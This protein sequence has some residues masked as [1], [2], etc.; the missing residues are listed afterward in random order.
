MANLFASTSASVYNLM[1]FYKG[2]IKDEFNEEVPIYR[3]AETMKFNWS[4]AQVNRP[5]R[6][7][8]NQGIGASTDGGNLPAIGRQGGV[9]AVIQAKYHWLRFGLTAGLLK[10]AQSDKGSFVRQF[11]FEMEMGMKDFKSDANRIAAWDGTGVLATVNT[12]AAASTSLVIAGR[13]SS[14]PALKFIGPNAVVDIYTSAGVLVQSSVTITAIASGGPNDSTATLTV[15][16]AVTCSATNIIVRSGSYNNEAQGLLYALDGGTSTIYSVDRSA[17]IQYQGNVSTVSGQLT[18]DS[19]Q[20]A[21]NAAEQ[22]GGASIKNVYTD[23]LSRRYYQKLLTA[24]K[25]YVNTVKGDGSFSSESK[26][27]LEWNGC[28]WVA[29]KDCPTR[30]FL[31][32]SD[33]IEKAVLCEMEP[34]EETGSAYIAQA[35]VDAWEVRVRHFYN[36]FNALPAGCAAMKSYTSP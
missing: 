10:A 24:D 30:I 1:N 34:A 6:L 19:I 36:Y 27:Y 33:A 9:Q 20:G 26:S 8:R 3:G 17:Y 29:D 5:L 21:Q 35:G 31:L 22:R 2:P 11:Q 28:P 4:G 16:P 32:P 14:E 13:E 15:S 23:F 7:L 12:N 25:R 18:L